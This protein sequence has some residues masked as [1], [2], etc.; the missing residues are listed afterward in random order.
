[1]LLCA[2]AKAMQL[3]MG[4]ASELMQTPGIFEPLVTETWLK[5]LWIDCHCYQISIQ[6]N[7][8][9]SQP[10]WAH[11]TELMHAFTQHGYCGQELCEL[12][13]CH[14]FLH[15]IWISDICDGTGTKVLAD[16]WSG[17]QLIKLPYRWPPTI[18]HP[19]YWPKWQQAL[20]NCFGL[21]RW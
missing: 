20:T 9:Q 6:T 5:C 1:M 14:M 19:A 15:A 21:D 17:N 10:K 4:L 16:C 7:L 11:D 12:N 3:E 2:L 8:L 18:T 13:R